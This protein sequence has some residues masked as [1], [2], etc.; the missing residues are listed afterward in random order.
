M[1]LSVFVCYSVCLSVGVSVGM[2]SGES[3]CLSAS[4]YQCDSDQCIS[5]DQVCDGQTHCLDYSDELYCRMSS[6]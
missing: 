3:V 5:A 4:E 1:Q 6:F 2:P